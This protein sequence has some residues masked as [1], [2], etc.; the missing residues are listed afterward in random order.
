MAGGFVP[1]PEIVKVRQRVTLQGGID[2][3]VPL[4][5]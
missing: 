1:L 3:P 2:V 5:D 4:A